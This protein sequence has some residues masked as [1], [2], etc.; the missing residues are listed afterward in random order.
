MSSIASD[1]VRTFLTRS[2]GHSP[3]WL[4]FLIALVSVY[5]GLRQ[6]DY[7]LFIYNGFLLA[8]MGAIALNVLMGTAGQVSVA[9]SGFLAIGAYGSA[10]CVRAGIG[11]PFSIFIAGL[12]AAAAGMIVAL[13]AMRLRG[14]AL[15]LGTIAA[16]YIILFLADNYQRNTPGAGPAG[17]LLPPVFSGSNLLAVQRKWTWLLT[18]LLIVLIVLMARLSL[19]RFGRALRMM[20]DHET[21]A[22]T[23]GIRVF[24]SKVMVFAVSSFIIGVEG[25]FMAYLAG[26][27]TTETFT[28][29]LAMHYLAM[30]LIGGPDSLFGAILGAALITSLPLVIHNIVGATLGSQTASLN[31]AQYAEIVYGLL[32]LV[33]IIA[34]RDGI[35][36]LLK[37]LAYRLIAL[38]GPSSSPSGEGDRHD[39]VVSPVS[40]PVS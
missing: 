21:V 28:L 17:F 19:G 31:G 25:G 9:T 39:H 16:Y 4:I 40:E 32:V 26:H 13:P 14:L 35:V 38:I 29:V 18:G 15:G 7:N 24:K 2:K 5:F 23:L 12:A 33:F 6:N 11:F 20:R 10:W 30:V 22:P 3:Y 27:V 1:G 36:G 37:S 34:A 8:A